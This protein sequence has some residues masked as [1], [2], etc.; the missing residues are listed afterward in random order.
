MSNPK[1]VNDAPVATAVTTLRSRFCDAPAGSL[2]SPAQLAATAECQHPR[3]DR[4]QPHEA[5]ESPG[6]N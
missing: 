3:Q 6:L 1:N 2:E 4:P 5:F